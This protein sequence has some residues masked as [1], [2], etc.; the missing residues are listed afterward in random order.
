M[1]IDSN[2]TPFN[3]GMQCCAIN[4]DTACPVHRRRE[5]FDLFFCF[6]FKIFFRRPQNSIQMW[7]WMNGRTVTVNKW[8]NCQQCLLEECE[9]ILILSCC[10]FI[11]LGIYSRFVCYWVLIM[12]DYF[13]SFIYVF[14]LLRRHMSEKWW[15]RIYFGNGL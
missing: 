2:W 11:F 12:W 9:I 7:H 10:I 8:S 6:N 1:T 13:T 14:F 15:M 4:Q 5:S 3:N